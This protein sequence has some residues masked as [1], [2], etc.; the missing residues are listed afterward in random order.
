MKKKRIKPD[1]SVGDVLIPKP[2]AMLDIIEAEVTRA[3]Y[4]GHL[5][6][7]WYVDAKVTTK[8]GVAS[9]AVLTTKLFIKKKDESKLKYTLI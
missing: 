8:T 5:S 9:R 6:G 1:I 2:T 7:E 4:E 3:P